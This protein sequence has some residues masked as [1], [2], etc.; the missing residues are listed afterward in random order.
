M[1]CIPSK[2]RGKYK[3]KSAPHNFIANQSIANRLDNVRKSISSAALHCARSP[4]DIQLLAVSKTKPVSDIL[5]AYEQGQRSF[6]ENYVQEGVSKIQD[7]HEL[8]DITWHYIGPLQSN[9]SKFIAEYFDWCQSIDRLKIAKRLHDQRGIYQAPLNICIQVNIDEETNKAG[10]LAQELEGFISQISDLNRLKLRGLMTIPKAD[11]SVDEQR[12]SFKR[13]QTLFKHCQKLYPDIDTL[14]MGMSK[15]LSL[16]IE[17]GSTMV[18]VGT[19]IFGPRT[20]TTDQQK[21][22]T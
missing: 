4:N 13:M 21:G 17:Y 8:S 12:N 19:E 5:L 16:A 9:K 15:D 14:S 22:R 18:R 20:N 1:C 3:L 6:G 11:A 2:S 7:L 10:V